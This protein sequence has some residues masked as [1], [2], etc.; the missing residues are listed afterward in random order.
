MINSLR[1]SALFRVA[2]LGCALLGQVALHAASAASDAFVGRWALTL[3]NAA[4]WLEVKKENGWID[5]S[6]LWGGGSVLPVA[7]VVIAGDTLTVT[8]IQSEVQRKNA[9]GEVVRKQ[10]LVSTLVAKLE[11]DTLKG[12]RTNARNNGSGFDTVE[13]TGKRIPALPAKPDLAKVKF[14]EPV[15]LLNGKDLAGWKVKETNMPNAWSVENGLL[16]NRP[17][18]EEPGKP[19]VRTANLRTDREF[20]DFNLKLEVNVP[21]GSNSGVYLRGIYEIQV[22]DSHGK[23]LDSHH[24]GALYS[25]I[26]PSANAEKPAGEW[27]TM[28]ITLVDRHVTVVL[29]GKTIIDNQPALGCTGGAMWSDEFRP[30]PLYLQGDHGP[31]SY[32]NIV[33]RPVVK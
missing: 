4:G 25:R 27:Q 18:K 26:V 12:K 29:N 19:K 6:L 7:H 20:E 3:P 31:V 10:T 33:L 14:G 32:R 11:G 13:F 21:Q 5:G 16:V 9:K 23:P 22:M 28:D 8:V 24:M 30:G 17:P 1:L 15:A 2:V